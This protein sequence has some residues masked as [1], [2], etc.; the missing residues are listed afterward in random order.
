VIDLDGFKQVNDTYGH[1]AGDELLRQ[2][3]ERLSGIATK[4]GFVS[5]MGGDE[6]AM[7]LP[8]DRA[9]GDTCQAIAQGLG[10][11]F[12]LSGK[13]ATIGAGI[14]VAAI[15]D[16]PNASEVLRRADFALYAA[17]A[18]GRGQ[19]RTYEKEMGEAGE[20]RLQ[21]QV[22]LPD[23]IER[24]AIFPLYQPIYNVEG[25][26]P[27]GAELLGRW[28]HPQLGMISPLQFIPIAEQ[29]GLIDAIGDRMLRQAC[30]LLARS[31]VPWIAVNVS[32]VE[33]QS[34]TFA[35]STLDAISAAGI[36]PSRIQLEITES[37]LLQDSATA[38][39]TL[40][41]LN[42]AGVRLALDDFGTGYSSLSYLSRFPVSK[43]KID[44]SFVS[45]IGSKSANAI[46][47]GIVAL[48]R[49]LDMKVTAEGVETE[50]QR[51]FL[52]EV[53]C[54]ELQGYLL[55]RPGSGDALIST[56]GSLTIG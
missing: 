8:L 31:S 46:V 18:A 15:A 1:A 40:D 47:K 30:D 38:R 54:D 4:D 36:A 44:H 10:Q 12:S 41:Y 21:L 52:K 27:L 20:R 55:A 19:W 39:S 42:A 48:A 14:G 56:F 43:I 3:G 32:T 17:K 22:D 26:R 13:A 2:V 25:D 16:A 50:C 45:Q 11:S 23:A 34:A 37:V 29:A 35:T 5:R 33:L 51:A 28:L 24:G 6:F 49:S 53:G 9:L 7:I